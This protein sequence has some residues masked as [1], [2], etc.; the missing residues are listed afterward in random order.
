MFG[1]LLSP[2]RS[3]CD[4]PL[5]KHFDRLD[6][7]YTYDIAIT[8]GSWSAPFVYAR[9]SQL[10]ETLALLTEPARLLAGGTDVFPG[11]G[12]SPLTGRIIDIS[13][14]SELRGIVREEA[15]LRIGAATTW[16]D[17]VH[18]DLPPAFDALR[19]A[20]REIGAV[21]IQNRGTIGGNLCNASPAADGIPPLLVLDA[22]VELASVRG[23]RRMPLSQFLVGNRRTSRASDEILTAVIAPPPPEGARSTFLKLGARR[24]LVI[25]IAMA[26][27]L[28]D[29][30]DQGAIRAARIAVGACSAVAQRLPTAEAALVGR[31]VSGDFGE[32]LRAE[33]L[34][35]LTP[36]GDVRASAG[37]RRKAA[38]ILIRRAAA[39]C[40]AGN[41]GGIV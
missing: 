40:G 30:D 7:L 27:V 31:R 20:A 39:L 9:P 13:K 16:T 23:V 5:D 2:F 18:A 33:H 34:A 15:G 22:E 38:L 32:A 24:Y 8:G 41:A 37:Y 1:R 14:V 19:A 11:A 36:I 21:Q 35:E 17:L 6:H 12:E 10:N 4:A 3:E 25:S 26:A 29:I 28:L